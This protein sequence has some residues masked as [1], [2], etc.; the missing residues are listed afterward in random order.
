MRLKRRNLAWLSV[1][2]SLIVVAV[3]S[4]VAD[5][6]TIATLIGIYLAAA[7][8]TVVEVK[9]DKLLDRSRSSLTQ[10]RMTSEARAA[11]ERARRRGGSFAEG[12][13]LLDIGLITAQSNREGMVMRRTRSVSL[14]D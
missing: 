3:L 2:G 5:P 9:P 4:G 8:A 14:D 12:L 11:V 7:A 13:T 10:M 6:L 1:L